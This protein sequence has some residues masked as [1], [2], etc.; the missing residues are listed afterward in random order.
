V[1]KC[2]RPKLQASFEQRSYRLK[3][4]KIP[5]LRH[6]TETDSVSTYNQYILKYIFSHLS[7]MRSR[8]SVNLPDGL[9]SKL[10]MTYCFLRYFTTLL[11]IRRL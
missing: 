3:N 5:N 7:S 10:W 9:R 6:K 2:T 4:N 8:E 1:S 11:Q